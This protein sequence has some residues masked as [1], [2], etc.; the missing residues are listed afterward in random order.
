MLNL[1][2]RSPWRSEVREFL[3]LAVPLAS[4]QLAQAATGFVDT[5]MMGRM[6][7]DVL[8]AG[9][10]AAIIFLSVMTTATGMV[11]G[12][13]P[14]IAEAFGAGQQTRI[15]HLAR[16]GLWLAVLVAIP[17]MIV[18]GHLDRFMLQAGQAAATVR[19][20]DTYLDIILWGMIPVIGFASLRATV[21]ALSLARPVMTIMVVGTA[22][23]IVGNYSLG[24][25]KFGLPQMGLA[26]LALASVIAQWGMFIALALY[27]GVHPQLSQY[28]I[29]QGF[30]R[31]R[32]K[33]LWQVIWVGVP[34]GIFSGLE[35][36]FFMV[37]MFWVGTLGTDA[38][39]AHQIVF[40]TI[41]IVFMVPLGIS[42]AT[43]VRVGQWLGRRDVKGIQQAAWVS[44]GLSTLF[45]VGVSIAFLLFP[46]QVIS[47]YLDV[48]NPD[49]AAVIALA[50]PLLI[51]A[52]IA[53]VLDGFQ[54]AIYGSLQGL[55]D[56]QVPMFLNVL[57]YWGVGLS[58][59][60]VLGFQFGLGSKG[61]WIGQSV[62]IAVVAG[63]F[64]WRLRRLIAQRKGHQSLLAIP[65]SAC[66]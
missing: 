59:G 57:G 64:V 37:I 38:L 10:L 12:V 25:G 8:A 27:V 18:M 56:T 62:A 13:S 24:F 60:Y 28:H 14:L 20:A 11:M 58:V 30:H 1:T 5:V 51:I 19:L 26:G 33:V 61:L 49:N 6:G 39:A 45:V 36:G 3:S 21:S 29:F 48:Q 53:Q 54:K 42:Y 17:V 23:N 63:L 65:H 15:Q 46:Q 43:T 35:T 16:Q 9:G 66:D 41:A 40:Q 44:I 22:F 7:S 32:L 55:Q 31:L 52:A 50:L 2:A 34:I 47:I 4:A